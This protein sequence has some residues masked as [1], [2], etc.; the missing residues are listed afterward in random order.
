MLFVISDGRPSEGAQDFDFIEDYVR[1]LKIPVH[2]IGYGKDAD[3]IEL[4][5][6]ANI[7]EAKF[8]YVEEGEDVAQT[9]ML[10]FNSKFK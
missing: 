9:L 8:T 2:T 1:K 4:K 3:K 5:K 6:L 7:N 10:L